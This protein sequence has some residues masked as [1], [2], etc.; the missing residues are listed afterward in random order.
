MKR[1]NL[2]QIKQRTACNLACH[3]Q[4]SIQDIVGDNGGAGWEDPL[5]SSA[6][7]GGAGATPAGRVALGIGWPSLDAPM[8]VLT[9]WRLHS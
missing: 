1:V 2:S 6:A 8:R 9:P 5:L 3:E 4:D 7:F